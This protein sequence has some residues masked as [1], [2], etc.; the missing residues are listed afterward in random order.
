MG[1]LECGIISWISI[2]K[3][4]VYGV[5]SLDSTSTNMHWGLLSI[6][7]LIYKKLTYTPPPLDPSWPKSHAL[8]SF[9]ILQRKS[10]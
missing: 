4:N 10:P 6:G 9:R 8:D 1:V 2:P 5:G 7:Y 3:F